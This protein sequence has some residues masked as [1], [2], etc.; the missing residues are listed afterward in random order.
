MLPGSHYKLCAL[1]QSFLWCFLMAQK[2]CSLWH[3]I[4]NRFEI[5]VCRYN[6]PR[7]V[8]LYIFPIWNQQFYVHTSIHNWTF[9]PFSQDSCLA[10]LLFAFEL[11]LCVLILYTSGGTYSLKS[12]L[13]NRFFDKLFMVVL[14][15]L[16]VFAT[17][18]FIFRLLFGLG[19]E[20]GLYV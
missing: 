10:S 13:K 4:F 9:Q 1:K 6:K 15:A 11:M 16:R 19:Y 8:Y 3:F 17:K 5:K 12:A 18:L 20:P 2:L 7:L 14:I